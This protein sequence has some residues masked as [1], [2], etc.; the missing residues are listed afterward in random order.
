[1]TEKHYKKG[2]TTVIWKPSF[3]IHSA[4]C[5]KNLPRVFNPNRKPWIE[6]E[7]A[8]EEELIN[9]IKKCPSGALSYL[10]DSSDKASEIIQENK[11]QIKVMN[12]GPLIISDGCSIE[13]NGETIEKEGIVALCRCGHSNNKP[14]CD[15][16]HRVKEFKD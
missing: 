3:C 1:M 7:H 10:I 8:S 13:Y 15:G 14:F 16:S 11:K 6:T 5:V 12:S 4:N 9:T 2:K